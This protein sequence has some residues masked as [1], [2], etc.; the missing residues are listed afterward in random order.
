VALGAACDGPGGRGFALGIGTVAFFVT[1][2]WRSPSGLY[3]DDPLEG[4][5]LS[6]ED[7]A[8]L[9]ALMAVGSRGHLEFL[10]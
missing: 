9:H 1:P 10:G 2:G 3:L 4:I 7:S 6:A 8:A 5:G